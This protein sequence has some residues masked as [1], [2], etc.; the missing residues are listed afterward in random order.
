MSRLITF[1]NSV[2]VPGDLDALANAVDPVGRHQLSM[3][4]RLPRMVVTL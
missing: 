2:K 4:L 3:K 1:S